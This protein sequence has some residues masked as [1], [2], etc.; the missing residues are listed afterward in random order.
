MCACDGKHINC[1]TAKEWMRSQLGVWQFAYESRDVRDKDVHPA[2]FPISLARKVISL[3]THEGEL[4][5]NPLVRSRTTLVAARDLNRNAAG[6]DHQER[7]ADV[8]R[9]RLADGN[10]VNGSS[11]LVVVDHAMNVPEYLAPQSLSLIW[12]SPPYA[13]LLNRRRKNKS[14]RG[15]LRNND[16]YMK[17]EQYSQDPGTSARSRWRSTPHRWATSSSGCS[18]CFAPGPAT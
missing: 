16:Q 3:F 7:Y 14:R 8:C 15:D 5:L 12:T 9:R 10:P 2:A 17:V 4:M 11:Q 1:M 6:F 18:P 13:N